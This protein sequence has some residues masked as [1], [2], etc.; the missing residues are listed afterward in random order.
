MNKVIHQ[1]WLGNNPMPDTLAKW[2]QQWQELNPDWQYRLW[3]DKVV[4]Q[5]ENKELFLNPTVSD[6]Q[7]QSFQSNLVRYEVLYNYGGIYIDTD[8]EPLKPLDSLIPEIEYE[9]CWAAWEDDAFIANGIMG[10]KIGSEFL[11]HVIN[12]IPQSCWE[13]SEYKSQIQTGPVFFTS[14]YHK[15]PGLLKVLPSR[16]FYPYS[17]KQIDGTPIKGDGYAVHHWWSE[18]VKLN[19]LL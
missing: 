9:D 3:N 15:Y 6:Q 1:I 2:S 10:A 11:M 14:A 17:Y 13:N 4:D 7:K 8:F 12:D 18:R 16:Y 19:C 5:L